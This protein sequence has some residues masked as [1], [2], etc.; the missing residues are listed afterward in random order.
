MPNIKEKDNM[1]WEARIVA[2]FHGNEGMTHG[3]VAN[4]FL[5]PKKHVLEILRRHGLREYEVLG[6]EHRKWEL[7]NV[8]MLWLRHNGDI[9]KCLSCEIYMI[10]S[11]TAIPDGWA[12]KISGRY[13]D[14]CISCARE[15]KS[16]YLIRMDK[17]KQ[18]G[19]IVC[20]LETGV[21]SDPEIHHLRGELG[22]GQ[23]RDHSRTIP[24]CPRH[25]RTGGHGI[26]RHSGLKTWVA[27]H[28]D[29]TYLLGHVNELI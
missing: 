14:I 19:C 3:E 8:P 28:G 20:L 27:R 26:A 5:V 10:E 22:V 9:D 1:R 12:W 23:K 16:E 18:L 11:P 24:L 13:G 21:W 4:E 17:L 6:R 7:E 25:H 2:M 15:M 29:E